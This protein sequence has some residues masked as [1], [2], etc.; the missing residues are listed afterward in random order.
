M[1][2]QL[3]LKEPPVK[4][5]YRYHSDKPAGWPRWVWRL[6]SL[7]RYR[8]LRRWAGEHG[9]DFQHR[10]CFFAQISHIGEGW[11]NQSVHT[12]RV[13]MKSG[14]TGIYL[15]REEGYYNGTGQLDYIFE[16][17]GYETNPQAL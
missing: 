5:Q 1:K 16:F 6:V 13:K 3:D 7:R 14:F 8:S 10:C 12:I 11:G 2:K 17:Q 15:V 4:L 9:R